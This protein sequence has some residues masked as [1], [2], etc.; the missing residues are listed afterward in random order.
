MQYATDGREKY[1]WFHH[2]GAEPF[3]DL[4][5]D[6]LECN[7]LATNP[8]CQSRIDVWRERLAGIN[9]HRGEPRGRNGRLVPQPD[10][11]LS[12]SSN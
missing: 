5:A 1:I 4:E 2:T 12:L 10:S 9:E 8:A 3:F 11:A 7:D 6:P